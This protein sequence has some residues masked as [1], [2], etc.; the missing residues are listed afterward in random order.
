M[1]RGALKEEAGAYWHYRRSSIR[2]E[3]KGHVGFGPLRSSLGFA[4]GRHAGRKLLLLASA[5]HSQREAAR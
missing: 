1:N 4:V 2:G 3:L 5:Q